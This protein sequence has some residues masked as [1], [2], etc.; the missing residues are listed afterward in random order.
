MTIYI[1]KKKGI[2]FSIPV[3]KE[4]AE[5][6]LRCVIAVFVALSVILGVACLIFALNYRWV[7]IEAGEELDISRIVKDESA[8]FG[9]DFDP[10]CVNHAGTHYFDVIT[11]KKI[12]KVCLC[13]RDTKAPEVTVKDIQCA[14]GGNLPTPKDFIATIYEP[15]DFTG[16]YVTALPEIKAMGTYSAEVRFTD[17][18]GNRTKV[19][20]VNATIVVDTEPPQITLPEQVD[21]TVGGEL[22][23]DVILSDNCIGEL[24]Y[25]VNDSE[26]DL[27]KA[28]RYQAYVTATDA[29]GNQSAPVTV[30]VNVTEPL[31]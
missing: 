6:V 24:S 5:R 28:G 22:I 13:V 20:A 30:T 17:A 21:V 23:C 2:G 3:E 8:A 29:V 11:E 27:T 26:V 4:S 31:G 25:T 14:V 9:E 1:N 18:S 10:D 19:F 16:E 15:D 12:H 7:T